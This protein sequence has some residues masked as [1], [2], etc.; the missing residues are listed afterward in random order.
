MSS[1]T[2]LAPFTSENWWGMPRSA[3]SSWKAMIAERS[4]ASSSPAR[5]RIA[6]PRR[7]AAAFAR[8]SV[9]GPFAS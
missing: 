8:A 4:R 7:S 3:S 2:W 5:R 6:P 1:Y 9:Q